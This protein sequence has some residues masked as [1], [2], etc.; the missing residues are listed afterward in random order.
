MPE[1]QEI[2]EEPKIDKRNQLNDL[3]AKEWIQETKSFFFQ[4]GLG[5]NSPEAKYEKMH[6]A[7]FSF[8]DITKLVRFFTKEGGKVLDPFLGVGSTIKACLETNREGFGVELSPEWCEVTRQR[9]SEE[10][11]YEIDDEHLIC[12]DSR[13]LKQYFKKDFFDFIITSPPY[14]N[15]LEKKDHK[16]NERAL[17]G[18]ATKYS[19]NDF[20]LGNIED[21]NQFL[22]ELSSIFLNCYDILKPGKY[23]NIIVSDFRHRSEFVAFHADLINKLT[24]KKLKKHFDLKGMKILVQNAKKLY[25]YGYPFCYVENI[26]HQYILILQKSK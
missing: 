3:T 16:A 17:N 21:Y 22:D 11:N 8:T 13:N 5:A 20:D 4:K 19:E 14:W 2:V 12:G 18:H 26:H 6:P 9:L 7:P 25:P 23:M 24:N 10:S 15:I 1:T